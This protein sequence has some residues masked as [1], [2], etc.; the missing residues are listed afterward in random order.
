M[1][2]NG[3]PSL[4]FLEG[5]NPFR[6]DGH[7]ALSPRVARMRRQ[8]WAMRHNSFG[9]K[10]PPVKPTLGT[11]DSGLA[12][13]PRRA[14]H[15]T[16]GARPRDP[17]DAC[18]R[19]S[20][21]RGDEL[22]AV[23]LAGAAEDDQRLQQFFDAVGFGS[24]EQFGHVGGGERFA[25]GRELLADG[26][27]LFGQ[28]LGERQHLGRFLRLGERLRG[29]GFFFRSLFDVD[30]LLSLLGPVLK[31]GPQPADQPACFFRR[32]FGVECDQPFQNLFVGQRDGPAVGVA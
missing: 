7:G 26:E 22:V 30:G 25:G 21:S 19:R 29:C 16:I 1:Y 17:A 11:T 20:H 13:V 27:Y 32:S 15:V 12:L 5:R 31:V 14:V 28:L 9:V 24:G 18:G 4:V 8:P 23:D 10:A 3:V 6:V 2:P